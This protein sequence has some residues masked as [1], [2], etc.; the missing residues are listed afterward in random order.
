MKILRWIL[1]VL[2][3]GVLSL[4]KYI[5]KKEDEMY[6][7]CLILC[8][9]LS[10]G[11]YLFK[12]AFHKNNY[13]TITVIAD[14]PFVEGRPIRDTLIQ[15]DIFDNDFD[16]KDFPFETGVM[17]IAKFTN[18]ERAIYGLSSECWKRGLDENL[19]LNSQYIDEYLKEHHD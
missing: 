5:K 8:R 12:Y 6:P 9:K 17:T 19:K 15:S 13:Y 1:V 11:S 14:N 7:F 3:G 18:M 4:A 10:S 2:F 16:I